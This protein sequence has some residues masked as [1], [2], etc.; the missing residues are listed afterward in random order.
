MRNKPLKATDAL[1]PAEA[2]LRRLQRETGLSAPR[3][4]VAFSGGI[5]STALLHQLARARTFESFSIQALHVHHGLSP[6]ANAWARHCRSVCAALN[7]PL[8]VRRVGVSRTPRTSLEEEARRARYAAFEAVRADVIALAHHADDQ[9]ETVLLQLLRGA[10]P[11]GL[12]GMAPL[13]PLSTKGLGRILLWRPL[14]DCTRAELESYAQ[15]EELESIADESNADDRFKRN[16]IRRHVMPLLKQ[17]FPA[18]ALTLARAARHLAGASELIDALADADLAAAAEG[19]NL[20]V[21]PLKSLSDARL[22]NALRRWLDRSG[23]RQ[24]SEAR[25]GALIKAVR[26]SSNDTRLTWVHED[27][28]VRRH[29]GVLTLS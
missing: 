2:W 3:V 24:P 6:N 15:R 29:K 12:A 13:K 20:N 19:R 1:W 11:K 27:R 28:I 5:D 8:R 21:D 17:A 22:K 10:G 14:L 25:L 7:V 23:L 16:F 26:D 18:A 4:C 9:A